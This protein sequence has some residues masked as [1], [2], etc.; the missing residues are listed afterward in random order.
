MDKI[1][2]KNKDCPIPNMTPYVRKY[3]FKSFTKALAIRPIVDKTP[4][5]KPIFLASKKSTRIQ[6][7]EQNIY[8]L[9]VVVEPIHPIFKRNALFKY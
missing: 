9:P 5:M 6:L 2:A 7:T 4:P 8:S 1:E 3:S